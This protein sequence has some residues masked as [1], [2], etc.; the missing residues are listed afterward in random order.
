MEHI[1]HL[2]ICG[3]LSSQRI[4]STPSQRA[5]LMLVG[6]IA[7]SSVHCAHCLFANLHSFHNDSVHSTD[8]PFF[9]A[10]LHRAYHAREQRPKQLFSR[11]D[12]EWFPMFTH[13]SLTTKC[14]PDIFSGLMLFYCAFRVI[15]HKDT[16]DEYYYISSP[17]RHGCNFCF[18]LWAYNLDIAKSC[19]PSRD[20]LRFDSSRSSPGL[21]TSITKVVPQNWQRQIEPT[22]A[23]TSCVDHPQSVHV[24]WGYKVIACTSQVSGRLHKRVYFFG[25]TTLAYE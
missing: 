13:N 21:V 2:D 11:S 23:G 6:S 22:L 9:E 25:C 20:Y 7:R 17:Q 24:R 10:R 1:I 15:Q 14:V 16:T 3:V 12:D 18:V 19:R 8:N 4:L 5:K